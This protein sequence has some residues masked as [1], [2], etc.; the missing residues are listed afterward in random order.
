MKLHDVGE[1]HEIDASKDDWIDIVEEQ[2]C[3]FCDRRFRKNQKFIPK[4]DHQYLRCR[5]QSNT[6][7][8]AYFE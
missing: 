1:T 8:S 5:K 6:L 7:H 2:K 3:V 4:V